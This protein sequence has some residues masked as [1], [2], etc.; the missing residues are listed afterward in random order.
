L[1]SRRAKPI[2]K[3][4]VRPDNQLG[5]ETVRNLLLRL[6]GGILAVI[7]L[8]TLVWLPLA[9]SQDAA[10]EPQ[11]QILGDPNAPVTIIE[12]A[13]LTCPHCAQFH[14]EVLPDL[15]ERYI[16][17]GKVRLIYRDFPLDQVALAA[18]ALAHC[19]GPDRY[20]S[21]L[22]VM[23][24]TQSSWARAN[25]PITAL[26]R[27]GKLGG[28]SE[29]KM[30]ACLTDEALTDGILQTRLEGQNQYDIGSTPTFVIDGKTYSG[31]RDV[32]GFSELLDPLLD[33]S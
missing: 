33:Q 11:E 6:S 26:K 15:K 13:S 10:A 18:A 16:A 14:N 27:L 24:E 7:G 31:S 22:D 9:L 30:Q 1:S 23:F 25:D 20:F 8:W 29:E 32:E 2:L 28:L 12:Y 19:A 3:I 17:P 5:R 21:M 4:A